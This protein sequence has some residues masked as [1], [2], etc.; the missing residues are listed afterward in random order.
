MVVLAILLI[1]SVIFAGANHKF[2]VAKATVTG[3]VQTVPL[4][5]TNE[6]NLAAMDIPLEF[7]DGVTLKEVSFEGTR[8]EYFD[9]K[10]A[11]ID[12]DNNRVVIGLLPQITATA[13]PDLEAGEGV[14]ANLIFEINDPT[15]SEI[16]LEPFE[17]RSPGHFLGFVYHDFDENGVPHIRVERPEFDGITVALSNNG[18]G[19]LPEQYALNQNYPNPFNPS[20]EIAFDLPSAG[21]VK[22]SVFNILG[23]EVETLV[24]ES[25]EAGS[26]IV[27]WDAARYS[28]GVYFYRISA[29]SFSE[30]KKMLLLK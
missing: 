25:R 26:H 20:T 29:S 15:V 17:T 1:P 28:S 24:D 4:V 30:T 18:D 5:V 22:L 3:N 12:N 11:N 13:R 7:S 14:V 27:T 9:L 21:H 19:D 8:V 23:Q 16:T 2:A 10:I 6:A